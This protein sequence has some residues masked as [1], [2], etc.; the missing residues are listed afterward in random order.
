[1]HA[2]SLGLFGLGN[3]KLPEK[4]QKNKTVLGLNVSLFGFSNFYFYLANTG[5]LNNVPLH[6]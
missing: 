5:G 3:L 4:T 1:M 6:F 2:I